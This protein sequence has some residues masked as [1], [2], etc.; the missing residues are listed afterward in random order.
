MLHLILPILLII[1]PTSIKA[2]SETLQQLEAELAQNREA[3]R[4][5][6]ENSNK[7]IITQIRDLEKKITELERANGI[8]ILQEQ[9]SKLRY[10]SCERQVQN[11]ELKKL[12]AEQDKIIKHIE[13]ETEKDR[14]R[15]DDLTRETENLDENDPLYKTMQQ[16]LEKLQEQLDKKITPS[17]NKLEELNK[18]I[19]QHPEIKELFKEAR[20]IEE[21]INKKY[22]SLNNTIDPLNKKLIELIQEANKNLVAQEDALKR[23]RKAIFDT[24]K[25]IFELDPCF[26][27]KLIIEQ[28]KDWIEF[29]L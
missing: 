29:F 14:V 23:L 9:I 26:M 25:K 27:T 24:R 21:K 2:K 20:P 3:H 7:Q 11:P 15:I 19:Y 10:K 16:K 28:E 18:K 5:L 6:I 8:D 13:K 4:K 22:D 1:A 12:R 17:K